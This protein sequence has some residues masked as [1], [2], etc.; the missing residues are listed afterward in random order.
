MFFLRCIKASCNCSSECLFSK[1]WVAFLQLF[2]ELVISETPI[3]VCW[4]RLSCLN[5]GV[6]VASYIIF[7]S[8]PKMIPKQMDF[9][10]RPYW[11]NRPPPQL[12]G[13]P[14]AKLREKPTNAVCSP[15]VFFLGIANNFHYFSPISVLSF[16]GC[17]LA[18]FWNRC[19]PDTEFVA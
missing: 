15:L 12:L 16:V 14:V 3:E 18:L 9:E 1:I 10:W 2:V 11:I 5:V 6:F 4:H 19:Y 13:H 7:Q 8:L 17:F